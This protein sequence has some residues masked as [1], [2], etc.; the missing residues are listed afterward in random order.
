MLRAIMTTNA[1][2]F[3]RKR[4]PELFAKGV[5]LLEQRA[6]GGSDGAK[7]RLDDIGGSRG[8]ACV[9]FDGEG[10][11][12]FRVDG[13]RCEA[14]DAPPAGYPIRFAIG[15]P[16]EAVRE[17][18]AEGERAGVLD[19]PEAAI[20]AASVA[21]KR[22]E[23]FLAPHVLRFHVIIAGVPDLGDVTVAIGINAGEPPAKP[24]FTATVKFDD[25]EDLRDGKLQPQQLL[26]GG[27]VRLAGN[28][29]PAMQIA[30]QLMQR[31]RR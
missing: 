6:S 30:M 16:A 20:R 11:V 21:S 7:A 8:A 27:K 28:Y 24:D 19:R 12:Y 18:I 29:A 10:T 9:R 26:M 4:Y 3:V 14:A 1:L 22:A 2:D 17:L 13:G 31:P 23:E 25:L 15:A 5:E